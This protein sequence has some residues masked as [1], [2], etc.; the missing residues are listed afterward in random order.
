MGL[1]IAGSYEY[2]NCGDYLA[3]LV[4]DSFVPDKYVW[5]MSPIYMDQPN[6]YAEMLKV[7]CSPRNSEM[8]QKIV[9]LHN[10]IV[11]SPLAEAMREQD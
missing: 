1:P 4:I 7:I 3:T 8:G 5:I 10:M 9:D 2:L 6:G 11:T